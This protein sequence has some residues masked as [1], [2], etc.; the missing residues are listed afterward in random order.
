MTIEFFNS[1][2]LCI[3]FREKLILVFVG[4]LS[5]FPST[6]MEMFLEKNF[7]SNLLSKRV[8]VFSK[9]ERADKKQDGVSQT[10]L[11]H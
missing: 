5:G 2:E 11:E 10:F 7:W 4:F 9:T 8:S 3:S 1:H 6:F